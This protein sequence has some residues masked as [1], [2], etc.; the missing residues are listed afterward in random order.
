MDKDKYSDFI[1]Q[2]NFAIS[3]LEELKS[4][5]EEVR[6]KV[7]NIKEGVQDIS[8]MCYGHLSRVRRFRI[9]IQQLLVR[10]VEKTMQWMY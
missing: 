6:Q 10:K 5:L 4:E 2:V 9:S 1:S 7:I 8:L 3:L